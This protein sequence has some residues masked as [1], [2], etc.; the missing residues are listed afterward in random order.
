MNAA[1]KTTIV[2]SMM[3]AALGCGGSP[4]EPR[5]TTDNGGVSK[6]KASADG[7]VTGPVNLRNLTVLVKVAPPPQIRELFVRMS[8]VFPYPLLA[9]F[10]EASAK[11]GSGSGFV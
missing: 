11:G 4:T 8:V 6:Q 5:L 3:L 10:F 1:A 7:W 2:V 9:A